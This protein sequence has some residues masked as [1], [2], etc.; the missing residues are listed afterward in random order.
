MQSFGLV[1]NLGKKRVKKVTPELINWLEARGKQVFLPINKAGILGCPE[2][3]IAEERLGE[4]DCLIALGGDGTLLRAARL[5]SDSGTPILGVNLGHLG[6]LTEIELGELYPALTELL[7]GNFSIEERMMLQSEVL[8]EEK[9][10]A[11][12]RALNDVVITKGAFS[13]MLRLEVYV[14][15]AYLDTYPA[16]GLIL[17]T[18]TGST[19]Y[20][21][22]AGGPLVAPELEVTI[23]TPICPHTLYA[24]PL[25]VPAGQEVRVHV[26]AQ[27]AEVMLTVDGQQGLH[28]QDGDV[29]LVNRAHMPA[30]LV[31]LKE[32]SFY[33]LVREKLRE[34]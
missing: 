19:A 5:V 3:G 34:G 31:R 18:P 16:D 6:F 25:V 7:A 27:G 30:R 21:L 12:Y 1:I 8:R 33:A 10:L 4:T 2:R 17:S 15:G 9:T 26:H 28:L 22:S 13:R 24:R 32:R 11:G 23:L 29:I 20:S 14:R